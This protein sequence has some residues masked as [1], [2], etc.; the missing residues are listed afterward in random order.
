MLP[1]KRRFLLVRLI[2]RL[3]SQLPLL[4]KDDGKDDQ[5]CTRIL[6]PAALGRLSLNTFCTIHLIRPGSI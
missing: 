6:A 5:C 2:S 3:T 4:K 1:L